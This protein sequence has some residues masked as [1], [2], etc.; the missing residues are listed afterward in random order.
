M[1]TDDSEAGSIAPMLL[2]PFHVTAKEYTDEQTVVYHDRS[3]CGGA[4]KI[5]TMHRIEGSGGRRR[6]N[7]CAAIHGAPQSKL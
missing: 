4:K 1:F 6:C 7:E 5:Q 3:E 2:F